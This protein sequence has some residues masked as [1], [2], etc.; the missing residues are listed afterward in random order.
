MSIS[1]IARGE[2]WLSNEPP[3]PIST[4]RSESPSSAPASPAAPG[5]PSGFEKALIRLGV[6]ISRADAQSEAAR[7]GALHAT[8]PASMLVL[9]ANM[10]RATETIAVTTKLVDS[11]TTSIRT[12]L[13]TKE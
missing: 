4:Q 8:S 1:N 3:K 11:A 7:S 5:E 12:V 10:Y 9:Q 6:A 13:S 2:R